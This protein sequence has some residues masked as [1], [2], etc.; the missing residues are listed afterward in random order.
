MQ[1]V[2][3]VR[4]MLRAGAPVP[5]ITQ[6]LAEALGFYESAYQSALAVRRERER[7]SRE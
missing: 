3:T 7:A 1:D 6:R 5:P 2:F 4:A